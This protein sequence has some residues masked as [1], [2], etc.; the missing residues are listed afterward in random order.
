MLPPSLLCSYLLVGP[1]LPSPL[2]H[3]LLHQLHPHPSLSISD[4][5][6]RC[7]S[8]VALSSSENTARFKRE[9]GEGGVGNS[10]VNNFMIANVNKSWERE[11]KKKYY[12][13]VSK[14]RIRAG[15]SVP[16]SCTFLELSGL[17]N[18]GDCTLI[19]KGLRVSHSMMI[20]F[21]LSLQ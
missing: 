14:T 5:D 18:A 13:F 3:P 11:L 1:S 17:V 16:T 12:V 8:A 9:W 20:P 21:F 4:L 6:T 10:G 15:K 19:L 7:G 2:S